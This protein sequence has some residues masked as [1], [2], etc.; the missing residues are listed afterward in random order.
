[1]ADHYD[2][3]IT[4]YG[5]GSPA[6]VNWPRG[7]VILGLMLVPPVVFLSIGHEEYLLSA[8][9]GV[10][11]A[12]LA[13]PGGSY[14]SRVSRVAA[15]GLI[16]AALT[17]LG[18][19]ISAGA[20]GWLVLLASAVTLAGALVVLLGVRKF[21]AGLLLNGWLIIVLGVTFGFYQFNLVHHAQVTSHIWAQM[22]AWAGGTALWIAVT[23]LGCM[24]R[25]RRGVP[26]T[27]G[28]FGGNASRWELTRPRVMSAVI[29][30]VVIAGTAELAFAASLSHGS[31]MPVPA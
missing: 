30:A 10:L 20:W 2:V 26:R 31:W 15:F 5:T 24:V 27:V 28:E 14:R 11:F 3:I 25:E 22:T 19:A 23:F 8:V 7:A 1:M 4:G 29:R 21:A 9:F 13:D 6:G 12:G 18:F 17:A 16:A